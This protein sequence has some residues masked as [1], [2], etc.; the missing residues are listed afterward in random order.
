MLGVVLVELQ[1]FEL[2]GFDEDQVLCNAL[3]LVRTVVQLVSHNGGDRDISR[4]FSPD[5][6]GD[7]RG[8]VVQ[9]RDDGVGIQQVGS[10]R[11]S[12]SRPGRSGVGGFSWTASTKSASSR[13]GRSSNHA[14]F[15]GI[16]SRTMAFPRRLIRTSRPSTR[17]SFGSRTACERPDQKTLA[18]SIAN[19]QCDIPK[20]YSTEPA[21]CS[22]FVAV[23]SIVK[24][25]ASPKFGSHAASGCSTKLY[26]TGDFS[27]SRTAGMG[28]G[29]R[30]RWF[31]SSR[32]DQ[33][34]QV[35][36][37]HMGDSSFRSIGNT[38]G[39]NGF[40]IGSSR[41]VSSSKLKS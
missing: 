18:V 36:S 38:F 6:L 24:P 13:C 14:Q 21:P 35:Y 27:T 9:D 26:K 28:L 8:R 30:G 40:S 41:H 39:P 10:H 25:Q 20:V 16:G 33:I 32:P 2:Q 22:R 15:S 19:L 37:G 1:H 5:P 11:N 34:S 3:A 31:E 17:Y 29:R 23:A 12:L 7:R 4:F